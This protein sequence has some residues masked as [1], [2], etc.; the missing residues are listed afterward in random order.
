MGQIFNT[1]IT[2]KVHGLHYCR[3]GPCSFLLLAGSFGMKLLRLKADTPGTTPYMLQTTDMDQDS[4]YTWVTRPSLASNLQLVGSFAEYQDRIYYANGVDWPI[5][6]D[7]ISSLFINS[8]TLYNPTFGPMGIA[9][10]LG[11][12]LSVTYSPYYGKRADPSGANAPYAKNYYISFSSK[13]GESELF[14]IDMPVSTEEFQYPIF[15]FTWSALSD[16]ITSANFYRVPVGGIIPQFVATVKRIGTYSKFMDIYADGELGVGHSTL[17]GR[18]TNFRILCSYENRMFGI[19]GYGNRNRIACSKAGFPDVWPPTYELGLSSDL[20]SRTI[21]GLCVINGSLYL[22]L[23]FGIL[24]LYGSSPDNFGFQVISESIGCIA[25]STL[26]PFHDGRAFLSNDGLFH[27]NGSNLQRLGSPALRDMIGGTRGATNLS[28]ACLAANGDQVFL[29]YRDDTE[30]KWLAVGETPLAGLYPNRTLVVNP[31]NDRVGV[32]DDW[33]FFL[34]C[35]YEGSQGITFGGDVLAYES[36]SVS[37]GSG[38]NP[39][40]YIAII[41]TVGDAHGYV[42]YSLGGYAP[43]VR[44]PGDTKYCLI[45]L[46]PACIAVPDLGYH[47]DSVW[48]D[49]VE[50]YNFTRDYPSGGSKNAY[51]PA[52]S[53]DHTFSATFSDVPPP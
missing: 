13:F 34:S 35:P 30:K 40:G 9:E 3:S 26:F 11:S 32:I 33:A 2:G 31:S 19:G 6:I 15:K 52:V 1:S 41:I 46:S 45:G 36:D 17:V 43:N 49:G 25:P 53:A 24:R 50:I 8:S 7:G 37:G 39:P 23:D 42:T 27:F 20:G 4:S 29:S 18:A 51:W 10:N 14:P 5:R 22:F 38:E 12:G 48:A 44:T 21:T 28:K 47:C 16:S